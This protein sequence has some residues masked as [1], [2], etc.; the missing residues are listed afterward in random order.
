[1]GMILNNVLIGG[2]CD[3]NNEYDNNKYDEDEYCPLIIVFVDILINS[4]SRSFPLCLN[5]SW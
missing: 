4:L 2:G 3:D 5:S 1:M